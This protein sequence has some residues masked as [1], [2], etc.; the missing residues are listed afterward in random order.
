M[1]MPKMLAQPSILRSTPPTLD[2]EE[3]ANAAY[4]HDHRAK[5][6]RVE[7]WHRP[8]ACAFCGGN[9]VRC[10][11]RTQKKGIGSGCADHGPI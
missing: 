2:G 4:E 1:L 11:E 6:Y 5:Q 7:V 9:A 3:E 8:N 10:P